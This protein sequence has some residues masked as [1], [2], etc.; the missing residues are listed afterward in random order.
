MNRTLLFN[1][2]LILPDKVSNGWILIEDARIIDIGFDEPPKNQIN[3]KI[4]CQGLYASPGF[5][6]MH[7]HGAGGHDFM[8]GTEEAFVGA[9][10]MHLSHGT[11]TILPTCL[12][13]TKQEIIQSIHSFIDAK[14]E[15]KD[16]MNLEGLHL[17][18]PYFALNMAGGQDKRF[19]RD[20]EPSEY[21]EIVKEGKGN[22]R[23]WSIAPE[24]KGA[25]DMGDYLQSNGIMPA[26]A[27]TEA[28]YDDVVKAMQHGYRHITHLYS[29]TSTITRKSGFRILGV[30]ECAYLFDELTSEIIAD[31]CHL[32]PE[33]LRMIIKCI[34]VD[35]LSLITD[36][37]RAAG[38][39]V[40]E[41]TSGSLSHGQKVIIEDGIAKMPDR[42]CFAGS[43]ATADRLVRT[44]WKETGASLQDS[45]RMMS[46]NPSR[47]LGISDTKGSLEKGKDA[48][49]V[50]FDENVNIKSVMYRGI[51]KKNNL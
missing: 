35:R 26:I 16:E 5:I 12:S 41:S 48:D 23:R 21:K 36:S 40:K 38:M 49:I 25:L 8:D 32:P 46:L 47:I 34:G 22:I 4:D 33:L 28:T 1:A 2:K 51:I 11:T 43:I 15:M 24:L 17:E 20:P 37:L 27:H 14:K 9:C 10:R 18:G 6:D 29:C 39:D 42:T 7:T 44:I 30:T 3:L 31:G 50:L 13:A 45:I 19:I